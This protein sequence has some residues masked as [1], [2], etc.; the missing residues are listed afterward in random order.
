MKKK[1]NTLG[2]YPLFFHHHLYHFHLSLLS[3]TIHIIW[4]RFSKTELNTEKPNRTDTAGCQKIKNRTIRF[5]FGFRFWWAPKNLVLLFSLS[6]GIS[7]SVSLNLS[8]CL[9]LTKCIRFSRYRIHSQF[10]IVEGE[11]F[12]FGFCSRPKNFPTR[13][14]GILIWTLVRWLRCRETRFLLPCAEDAS[15]HEK[16]L[17]CGTAALGDTSS[18]SSSHGLVG[19]RQGIFG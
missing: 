3:I 15:L 2:E 12:Q 16:S 5:D 14:T 17:A 13:C 18:P 9:S 4:V 7:L 19:R 1:E 6:L 8:H 10:D 11:N